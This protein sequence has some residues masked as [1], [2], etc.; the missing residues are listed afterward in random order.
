[1]KY[2]SMVLILVSAFLSFKHGWDA[3]RSGNNPEE[4]KM[5][6]DLGID[7]AYVPFIGVFTILVGILILFPKT[8][9]L[10]N[11]LNAFSIVVIMSLA[12]HAG[13]LRIALI[14]I[15]FLALPL[16]LIGLKYP[17]KF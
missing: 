15:P 10:G 16:V 14:E 12:L 2:V 8:F 13:H 1:M 6:T 5:M 9:V 4:L 3:L 17:F 7:K 11:I